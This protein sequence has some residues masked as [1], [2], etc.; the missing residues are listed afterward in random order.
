MKT[1]PHGKIAAD[2]DAIVIGGG[3][4]GLIAVR[5]SLPPAGP[6]ISAN[7]PGSLRTLLTPNRRRTSPRPT[8]ACWS[9]NGGTSSAGPPSPRKSSRAFSSRGRRTC[10][11]C[12]DPTLSATSSS[13]SGGPAHARVDDP[14]ACSHEPVALRTPPHQKHGLKV[15]IRP[16]SS[17]TPL[18]DGSGSLLMGRNSAATLREITKFSRKD[19]DAFPKYEAMLDKFGASIA[20]RGPALFRPQFL[21]M[22]LNAPRNGSDPYPPTIRCFTANNSS[23]D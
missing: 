17:F 2:Y 11:A 21:G 18:R 9:W 19:A 6:W 20:F 15:H 22:A 10:S 14:Y 4:N 12:C 3:H 8:Y 1:T 7:E 16:H 5:K 13:R 23:H